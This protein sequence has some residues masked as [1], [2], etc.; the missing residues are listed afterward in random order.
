MTNRGVS[1]AKQVN[2]RALL[3]DIKLRLIEQFPDVEPGVVDALIRREC[4]RFEG[5]PIRDFIPLLVEKH[6][7]RQLVTRPS[8][9]NG[10]EAKR[11]G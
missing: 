11:S 10:Q 2:E 5:S 4:G 7:R 6:V 9:G 3:A 1:Q 8:G